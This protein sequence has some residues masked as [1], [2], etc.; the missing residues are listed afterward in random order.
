MELPPKIKFYSTLTDYDISD[1]D[2]EH[3]KT[4]WKTSKCKTMGDYH[5]LHLRTDVLILADVFE[6]FRKKNHV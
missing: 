4:V 5:D 6:N 2:Y 1:S 3:V